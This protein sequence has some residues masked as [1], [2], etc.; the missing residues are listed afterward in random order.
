VHAPSRAV[1]DALV[2]DIGE[3]GFNKALISARKGA[4]LL[5]PD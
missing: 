4:C 3:S 1:S 5:S 2:A